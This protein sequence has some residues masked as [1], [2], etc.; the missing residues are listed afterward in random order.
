MQQT[1]HTGTL[2][3]F[4]IWAIG[5]GLVISGESFGWNAGWKLV[6]PLGFFLPIL[7][8]TLMYFAL[9]QVQIELASVYP[10]AEGPHDYARRAFGRHLGRLVSCATLTEFLFAGPAI[11]NAIG[12]YLQFLSNG[13]LNSTIVAIVFVVLFA[14][15][16]ILD[17]KISIW[18]VIALTILAIIELFIYFVSIGPH[19]QA[20]YLLNNT[21]DNFRFSHLLEAMPYAIWMYLGIEGISL[22]T[23]HI[24]RDKLHHIVSAGYNS[25]FFTLFVLVLAVLGVAGGSM[26]WTDGVWKEMTSIKNNHPLPFSMALVLSRN[27]P[28]VQI[29]TFIGLFGLIASLQG[30]TIAAMSQTRLLFNR[31]NLSQTRT[32]KLLPSLIILVIGVLS[33]L[34]QK[35]TELISLSVFGAVVMYLLSCTSLLQLRRNATRGRAVLN[36]NASLKSGMTHARFPAYRSVIFSC[37]VVVAS[38]LCLA[39][40]VYTMPL[41]FLGFCAIASAF[42]IYTR[43]DE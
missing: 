29:F 10:E 34:L 39:S 25:A 32:R 31:A 22:L 41:Y 9:V 3:T 21:Q 12:E 1:S 20:H 4:S 23:Q 18:F 27:S 2:G 13:D 11:A 26:N 8:V 43:R 15:I 14:G 19:F 28:V 24:R 30:I 37:I 35:T 36:E 33:I 6:G 5:V 38:M 42:L 16:N 17:I 40:L 7:V